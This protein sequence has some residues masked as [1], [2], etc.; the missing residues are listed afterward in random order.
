MLRKSP[1]S[2]GRALFRAMEIVLEGYSS[3][4]VLPNL[5]DKERFPWHAAFT[6]VT[7]HRLYIAKNMCI[8]TYMCL[9][10]YRL[11]M[12]YC[13]CQI[14]LRVKHFYTNMEQ[15]EVLTGY[16][17]WGCRPSGDWRIRDIGQNFLQYSFQPG[18]SSSP[19]T[20][21]FPSLSHSS[22]RPSLEI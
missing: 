10:P 2:D 18:S 14:I 22:R 8:T 16:L 3:R 19:V 20:A 13:C 6:A 7:D 17:L 12:H 4:P 15:C 1:K 9:T 11:Y 21:T 5:Q